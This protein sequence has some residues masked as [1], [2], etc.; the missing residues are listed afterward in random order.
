MSSMPQRDPGSTQFLL[1]YLSSSHSALSLSFKDFISLFMRDTQR[2]RDTSRERSRLPAGSLM[3]DLILGLPRI[4]PWAKVR[5]STA[6]LPRHSIATHL[7]I[8]R[9]GLQTSFSV[10]HLPLLIQMPQSS[11]NF[12]KVG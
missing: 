11:R 10:Q 1:P 2:G 5:H 6:E 12:L 3:R 9:R 4:T 7:L 8:C